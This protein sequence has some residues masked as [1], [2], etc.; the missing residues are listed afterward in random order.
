MTTITRPMRRTADAIPL[1]ETL[2]GCEAAADELDE[3][4]RQAMGSYLFELL[5][6][7]DDFVRVYSEQDFSGDAVLEDIAAA[8]MPQVAALIDEAVRRSTR[9]IPAAFAG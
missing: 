1:W 5:P 9:P 4:L 6:Q 8:L 2:L 3:G 7:R